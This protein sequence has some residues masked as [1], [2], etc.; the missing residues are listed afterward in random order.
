MAT[1]NGRRWCRRRKPATIR[2]GRRCCRR[3]MAREESWEETNK[4]TTRVEG[5]W[6]RM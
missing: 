4:A 2:G 3:K 5:H 1:A 6:R